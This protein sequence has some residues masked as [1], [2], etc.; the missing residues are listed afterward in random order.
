[1]VGVSI[2][3]SCSIKAHLGTFGISIAGMILSD[4]LSLH[5][6]DIAVEIC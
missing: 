4:Q 2:S 1:M 3:H 6:D 5:L